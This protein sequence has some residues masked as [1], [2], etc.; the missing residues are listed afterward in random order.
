MEALDYLQSILTGFRKEKEK[1]G[2][3]ACMNI[4]EYYTE[5]RMLDNFQFMID[6]TRKQ[7]IFKEQHPDLFEQFKTKTQTQKFEFKSL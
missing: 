4:D 6:L 3:K 5:L 1:T 7:S 2:E